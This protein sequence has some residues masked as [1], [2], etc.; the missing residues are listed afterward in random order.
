MS[1]FHVAPNLNFVKKHD[2]LALNTQLF[3]ARRILSGNKDN[4]RYSRPIVRIAIGGIALGLA[5]MILSLAIV[6]GFQSEIR[7]KVIG[8]GSHIQITSNDLNYS[9]ESSPIEKDQ[10]FY[11]SLDTIDGVRHIQIY[12]TKPGILETDEEIQGII[13]KGIGPMVG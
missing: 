1:G 11:P 13:I 8:F 2:S 7:S 12:A 10:P 5:V 9:N 3:I 6:T 4:G